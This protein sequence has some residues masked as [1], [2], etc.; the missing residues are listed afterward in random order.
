MQDT[1]GINSHVVIK[2]I[3][4]ALLLG[5]GGAAFQSHTFGTQSLNYSE[6]PQGAAVVKVGLRLRSPRTGWLRRSQSPRKHRLS[7]IQDIPIGSRS[8]SLKKSL[9]NIFNTLSSIISVAIAT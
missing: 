2:R 9:L 8:R 7:T 1:C 6:K 4:K 3:H 5:L